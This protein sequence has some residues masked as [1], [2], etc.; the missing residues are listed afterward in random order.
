M[1]RTEG[2]TH[3][4]KPKSRS[5]VGK[6]CQ[7]L[8]I[9][10]SYSVTFVNNSQN[11]GSACL[12]QQTPDAPFNLMSL[13]WFAYPTHPSTRT[14]FQWSIDYSFVWGQT[15]TLM[16]GVTFSADQQLP[17]DPNGANTVT[18][19]QQYGSPQFSRLQSG[20]QP[21]MLSISCDASVPSRQI[22]IGIGMSGSATF[23]TQAMPNM[24]S[25]F[26]V[27]PSYWF[28]FGNYQQGQVLD[29]QSITTAV[30]LNFPSGVYALTVT[31]NAD[32]SFTVQ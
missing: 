7:I 13:A 21:G 6:T 20:G 4:R 27:S 25:V 14:T 15:G 8:I 19:T 29:A 5:R 10:Q 1:N 31:L 9:M 16:P 2:N 18:F 26:G 30:Q 17:A 23:A 22:S 24:T 3:R 11:T 12:Y 32:G 28:A